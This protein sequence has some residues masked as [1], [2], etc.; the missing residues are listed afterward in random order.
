MFWTTEEY[1]KG[2]RNALGDKPNRVW[3]STFNV[4]AGITKNAID[5]RKVYSITNHT[6]NFLDQIDRLD[7]ECNIMCG[8][9]VF[10]SCRE[11]CPDCEQKK[12]DKLKRYKFTQQNWSG[13][14]WKFVENFHLKYAI[15][16]YEDKLRVF[17]GGRNLG[18]SD[19]VDLSL[20]LADQETCQGVLDQAKKLWKSDEVL[21]EE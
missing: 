18:D 5:V 1:F 4:Y 20:E 21:I 9:P 7:V 14:N 6:A 8:L 19:W 10:I 13:L 2:L 17:I 11:D 3:L 12:I 15:F 16:E